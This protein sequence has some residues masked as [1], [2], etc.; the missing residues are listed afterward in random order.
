METDQYPQASFGGYALFMGHYGLANWFECLLFLGIWREECVKASVH[1]SP[2]IVGYYPV[3][4]R[5]NKY[6]FQRAIRLLA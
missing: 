5:T 6:Y 1:T 3:V 4:D 2:G